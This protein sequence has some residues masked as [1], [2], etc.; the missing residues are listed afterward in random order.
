M[1]LKLTSQTDLKERFRFDGF[2]TNLVIS[3]KYII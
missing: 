2:Y 3:V 1:V